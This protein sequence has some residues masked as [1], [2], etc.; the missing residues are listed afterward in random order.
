MKERYWIAVAEMVENQ[1]NAVLFVKDLRAVAQFYSTAL[2]MRVV[3]SDEHHCLLNCGGFELVVHQIPKHIADT[4]VLERP[5]TPRVSGAIRLDYPVRSIAESRR[6]ARALGGKID[7]K[8]PEWAD[9]DARFF[10][11]YDPEGNQFGVREHGG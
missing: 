11:G 10:F 9:P 2:G 3:A 1:V 4:I 5:P 6:A 8:P 7:D